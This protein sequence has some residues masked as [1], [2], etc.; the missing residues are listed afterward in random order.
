M[1]VIGF[2]PGCRRSSM[3]R[4]AAGAIAAGLLSVSPLTA[5]AQTS[6]D[7]TGTII[8]LVTTKE[9]NVPLAYSVV[10]AAS[11]GRERFSN[12]DG[13]FALTGLPTGNLGLRVRHLGYSPVDLVVTVRPGATDTIRVSLAHI[14]VR[15]TAVDERGYPEC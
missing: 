2:Y 7:S 15:L 5:R 12:V 1:Y 10:S 3:H 9:G 6:G 11:L 14:A 4:S 8:G 13:V